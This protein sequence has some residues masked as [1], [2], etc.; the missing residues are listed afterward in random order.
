MTMAMCKSVY[1]RNSFNGATAT[2][3]WMTSI[4]MKRVV[5]K[6]ALQWGHSDNAVDDVNG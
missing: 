6:R 5:E 3:L 2:T 1:L 4:E